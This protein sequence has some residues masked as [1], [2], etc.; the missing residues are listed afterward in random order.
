M[1]VYLL[2]PECQTITE[3]TGAKIG[4]AAIDEILCG[5]CKKSLNVQD[6]FQ[7]EH[8]SIPC[9]TRTENSAYRSI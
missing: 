8:H 3:G 2:C 9:S 5:T 7:K 4:D 6:A 1:D